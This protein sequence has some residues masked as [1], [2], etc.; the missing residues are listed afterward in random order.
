MVSL[1]SK[2]LIKGGIMRITILIQIKGVSVL[3][4][5]V[6]WQGHF[7]HVSTHSMHTPNLELCGEDNAEVSSTLKHLGDPSLKS[8]PEGTW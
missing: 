2:G 6:F 7:K 4:Q 1:I 8:N 3:Q 5:G